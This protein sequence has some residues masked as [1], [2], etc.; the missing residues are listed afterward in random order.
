MT[1]TVSLHYVEHGTGEPVVVLHGL[2]GSSRNWQTAAKRF[3]TAYRVITVDLRNHGDSPHTETMSYPEMAA[4][5]SALIDA[6]DMAPVT[7]VGHS[8]GGKVVMTLA[9][10]RPQQLRRLVSV[11]I[12]PVQYSDSYSH[13]V[14]AL[15]RLNLAELKDRA[16]AERQLAI[17]ITDPRLSRFLLH[18]LVRDNG[19]FSWRFNLRGIRS[20][21]HQVMSFPALTATYPGPTLFIRGELS[22]AV[23][24]EH[25]PQIRAYFPTATIETIAGGGHWLHSDKPDEFFG[26]VTRFLD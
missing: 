20:N 6:L 25:E 26:L 5:V 18:N 14:D 15:L 10:T 13:I 1:G 2:F 21:L 9:L 11:D 17:D 8:M 3:S 7:I 22:R 16:Q 12:A 19:T 23:R 4:D 24:S